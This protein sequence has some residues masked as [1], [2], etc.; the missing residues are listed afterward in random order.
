M[1]KSLGI[2]LTAGYSLFSVCKL[3]L[4]T[5]R[6]MF[7][8]AC[9][10]TNQMPGYLSLPLC[11][12][13]FLQQRRGK[14]IFVLQ[15][16]LHWKPAVTLMTNSCKHSS[17]KRKQELK[18]NRDLENRWIDRCW[19]HPWS[20]IVQSNRWFTDVYSNQLF[21]WRTSPVSESTNDR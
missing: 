13:T 17:A 7:K 6:V 4:A 14:Y 19:N 8:P 12:L 9:D 21:T 20:I 1:C 2:W 10:T 18:C 3:K 15:S 5:E 16:G 11:P